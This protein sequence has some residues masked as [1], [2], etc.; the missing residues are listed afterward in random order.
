MKKW[1]FEPGHS[2]SVFKA[3]HMMV[4]WVRGMFKN[5]EG[6]MD[7]DSET[8]DMESISAKIKS[9]SKWTDDKGRDGH[10][11]SEAFLDA[12]KFPEMTFQS[13]KV[14]RVG[15][16]DYNITGDLTIKGVTKEVTMYAYFLGI[17]DTPFWVGNEDKGPKKRAGFVGTTK[18][19][20]NDFGVSWNDK[21]DKGG[22]VVGNDVYIKLD[23]EILEEA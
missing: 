17:W 2:G 3:R 9:G 23:V 12:E 1:V 14:E 21:L 13:K 19:N 5:I 20:R 18:I 4:T 7:F 16:N 8:G 6:S 15:G 10:L 22:V 11:K